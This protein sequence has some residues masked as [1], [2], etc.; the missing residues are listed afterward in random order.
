M[1][2][3]WALS[4]VAQSWIPFGAEP[5]AVTISPANTLLGFAGASAT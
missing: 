2:I 3:S 5:N 4:A 1:T